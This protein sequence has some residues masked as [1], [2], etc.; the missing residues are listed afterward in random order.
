MIQSAAHHAGNAGHAAP[1]RRSGRTRNRSDDGSRRTSKQPDCDQLREPLPLVHLMN[2]EECP[3]RRRCVARPGSISGRGSR[4]AGRSAGTT[5]PPRRARPS[6]PRG[7]SDRRQRGRVLTSW[8]PG[9][10]RFPGL[11]QRHD[12][13]ARQR[14]SGGRGLGRRNAGHE[15]IPPVPRGVAGLGRADWYRLADHPANRGWSAHTQLRDKMSDNRA[16]SL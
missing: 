5:G 6:R 1:G 10:L 14:S 15:P 13:R 2:R 7:A 9:H 12:G 3:D 11:S 8:D 16:G 4:R